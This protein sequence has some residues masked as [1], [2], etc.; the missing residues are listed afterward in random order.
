MSQSI[1]HSYI[2]VEQEDA[3]RLAR[4][5]GVLWVVCSHSV[6]VSYRVAIFFDLYA[7]ELKYIIRGYCAEA[8][9]ECRKI[10]TAQVRYS[11]LPVT[12]IVTPLYPLMPSEFDRWP[13][14]RGWSA[15]V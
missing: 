2:L 1:M 7:Y 9:C 8:A 14:E 6:T 5:P 13:P 4:S 10:T 12:L 11:S 15:P 3:L